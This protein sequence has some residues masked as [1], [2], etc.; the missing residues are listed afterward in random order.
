MAAFGG[1]RQSGLERV[2][3]A[4]RDEKSAMVKS[5]IDDI[6]LSRPKRHIGRDL[7]DAVIVAEIIRFYL[8]KFVEIHN[9]VPS[10]NV[11]QKTTNWK[12]LKRKILSKLNLELSE[13]MIQELISSKSDAA[14][15]FLL[16]LRDKIFAHLEEQRR[17]AQARTLN[18]SNASYLDDLKYGSYDAAAGRAHT[19][20]VRQDNGLHQGNHHHHQLQSYGGLPPIGVSQH[21]ASGPPSQRSWPPEHAR[22][23]HQRNRDAYAELA[24]AGE[25]AAPLGQGKGSALDSNGVWPTGEDIAIMLE[26]KE[27]TI[28]ELQETV[29]LMTV[30]VRRLEGLLRVKDLRIEDLT[31]RL[32]N[33][34]SGASPERPPRRK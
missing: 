32:T 15:D 7:A 8:P 6:P 21:T 2:L 25:R 24:S 26:E 1:L 34:V 14:E 33:M 30:K 12:T 19:R 9:Y 10:H 16:M 4:S 31:S 27:Q 23:I 11:K 22:A 3:S 5:W 18:S 17:R 28:L 13:D 29:Q 20:L